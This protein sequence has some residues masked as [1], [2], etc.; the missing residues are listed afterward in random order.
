MSDRVRSE[1]CQGYNEFQLIACSSLANEPMLN[2]RDSLNDNSHMAKNLFGGFGECLY[3]V[4]KFQSNSER[5]IALILD[6]IATTRF[7]PEEETISGVLQS[8]LLQHSL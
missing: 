8:A 3:P 4:Q 7:K 5:R 6:R 1:D 2:F